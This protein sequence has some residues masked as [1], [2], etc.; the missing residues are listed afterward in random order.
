MTEAQLGEEW[1]PDRSKFIVNFR[2]EEGRFVVNVDSASPNAWRQEPYLSTLKRLSGELLER[3]TYVQ[4]IAGTKI[5][6]LTPE[7]ET[8]IDKPA[9][10]D[11]QVDLQLMVSLLPNGTSKRWFEAKVKV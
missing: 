8:V 3:Q 10:P 7:D 9:N 4:I 1:R 11:T 6:Y 5:I 2:P